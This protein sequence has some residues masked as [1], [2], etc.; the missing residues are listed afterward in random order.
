[1]NMETISPYLLW[2]FDF[3]PILDPATGLGIPPKLPEVTSGIMA[4][5][6]DMP[7]RIVPRSQRHIDVVQQEFRSVSAQ[8]LMKFEVEISEEDA[9]YNERYRNITR[10]PRQV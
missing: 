7:C 5:P 2:A 10:L 1:M 6:N 9:R 8:E 3:L 4:F